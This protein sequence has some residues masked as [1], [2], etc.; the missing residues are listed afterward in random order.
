[1]VAGSHYE[2]RLGSIFE[3]LRHTVGLIR[4][5]FILLVRFKRDAEGGRR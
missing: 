3:R 2:D 5:S 4:L 1:M